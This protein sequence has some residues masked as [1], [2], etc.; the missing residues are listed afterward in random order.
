MLGGVASNA[1]D[2]NNSGMIAGSSTVDANGP[3][4]AVVWTSGGGSFVAHDLGTL[5]GSFTYS[6]AYALSDPS[7]NPDPGQGDVIWVAGESVDS[8]LSV[9][10]ATVWRI[11]AA[12]NVLTTIDLEPSESV[13][14][15]ANDVRVVGQSVLVVGTATGG[16]M[17]RVW[18]LDLAG[19]VLSRTDLGTLGGPTSR[20]FSINSFGHAA[21][22]SLP[23]SGNP[24]FGFIYRNGA[25]S[26]LGSLGNWGSQASSLND[27]DVVV[28]RYF[29]VSRR[30]S[31]TE[32]AFVWQNGTMVDLRSQL[33]STARANWSILY[34]AF[35]VNAAGQIVGS[36]RVGK[37]NAAQEH[38]F[39]MSPAALQ[40]STYGPDNQSASLS[41]D[42]VQPLIA[43]AISR[44]EVAGVDTSALHGVDVRI[45]DLG[46][47][48]LGLASGNTIF[49]DANAAGW[50]WFVDAAPGNDAEYFT[51]GNQGEQGRM[52]LLTAIAH[53]L[54]HLL[55]YEHAESGT[56]H[57]SLAPGERHVPTS[58]VGPL[59]LAVFD[60]IF[61]EE[62]EKETS[63]AS[64]RLAHDLPGDFKFLRL[65]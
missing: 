43:E 64:D 50:G 7:P 63:M 29:N 52:D 54:G 6:I 17:A 15:I 46:G 33:S 39:L 36:G 25:M 42:S 8:S 38:G 59:E 18:E 10:H 12:A 9:R 34:G 3:S 32:N 51:P 11:D 14:A 4:H 24:A 20:G 30:G 49:L 55:G 53:E 19:N 13:N 45:A 65:R 48:K 37:G 16:S 60:L 44:W 57:E 41:M 58:V 40:A 47:T 62:K 56:M 26:S 5:G 1:Y 27:N 21:G 31:L 22:Q 2:A 23:T 28:G 61:I 35:D